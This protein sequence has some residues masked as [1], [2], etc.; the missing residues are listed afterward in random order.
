[1]KKYAL[2]NEFTN[3]Q[4]KAFCNKRP[5]I[6]L[7]T[8]LDNWA[9]A[10]IAKQVKKNLSAYYDFEIIP[11]LVIGN[12][13]KV[14]YL[15]R[16]CDLVHFFWRMDVLS[17]YLQRTA[18]YLQFLGVDYNDFRKNVIDR[19]R[20]STAVYD[21]LYL[22]GQYLNHNRLV[23]AT[24][25]NYYVSSEKLNR[26]YCEKDFIK[27]PAAVIE[28][29][30]DTT[31]FLPV[32]TGRFENPGERKLVV[33]WSGNSKWND[34]IEDFKG[35]NTI[36][37]PVLKELAD[38][39]YPVE[40]KFADRNEGMIPH[41]KMPEYYSQI[42]V[43]VCTSK[44]E[45]TPNPVLEAMACGVPVISTDVGIVPQV[46]GEKQ[47]EF[48]LKERTKECLREAVLRILQEPGL[49]KVLSLENLEQARKWDWSK[50]A[51]SFKAF[52]DR[53]LAGR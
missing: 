53:C 16:D 17:L 19:M 47:K 15:A 6:G 1:M 38:E 10:N 51:G 49:L 11:A 12:I 42:D 20:F 41:E 37:K 22:E 28:D 8:D 18:E 29:G 2:E 13:V 24:V 44:V 7:I 25:T 4:V 33:G 40:Y 9:F 5:K 23:F 27:R 39:G 3:E 50:R 14:L 46:F 32:N 52:F 43:Y 26:I 31:L 21:H 36:L 45:G 35:V 30:V 34:G 48:I